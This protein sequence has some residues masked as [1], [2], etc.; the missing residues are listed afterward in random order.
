MLELMHADI[1]RIQT[2]LLIPD[3]NPPAGP[4]PEDPAVQLLSSMLT[5]LQ[6]LQSG[7]EALHQRLDTVTRS[8]SG[9]SQ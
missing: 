4:P 3:G 7:Q 6:A 1:R 8:I 2:A 5:T 9:T